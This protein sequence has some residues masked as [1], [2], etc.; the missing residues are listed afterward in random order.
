[1]TSIIAGRTYYIDS[2]NK[3]TGTDSNFSIGIDLPQNEKYDH[4]CVLSAV[5]PKSYYLIQAGYNTF[6]LTES[7]INS[8]IT[9]PVGNYSATVFASVVAA[10]LTAQSVTN[11]NN[12]T[13]TITIANGTTTSVT[14]LFRYTVAGNGAVQPSLTFLNTNKL[15]EQFGFPN[16]TTQTFVNNTLTS[17]YVVKFQVED[18]LFLH[19]DIMDNG[20]NDV[21][22]EFFVAASPDFSNIKYQCTAPEFYTKKL[23][24]A[25]NNVY[26]FRLT[27]DDGRPIDLNG[28]NLV[29]TLQIYRKDPINDMIKAALQLMLEEGSL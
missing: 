29:I 20:A 15:Y 4:V 12:Y 25:S 27:D 14:G 11:G 2:H 19:S 8:T 17:A 5:I 28:L 3:L 24:Q 23:K 16:G 6:T 26:H 13:Y 9:I 10:L 22:Q 7:K 1:M 21:L 18:T